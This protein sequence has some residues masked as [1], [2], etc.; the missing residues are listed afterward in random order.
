[1]KRMTRCSSRC[2]RG[3]TLLEALIAFVV[4]AGGLLAVFRFHSTTM[5]TTA[6]SKIRS[7]AVA[8]AEQKLEE[9]R[10]YFGVDDAG[11]NDFDTDMPSLSNTNF[12]AEVNTGE[13]LPAEFAADGYAAAFTRNWSVRGTNPRQVDVRVIWTDRVG[14]AQ[15]VQLSTLIW[16]T[17]PADSAAQFVGVLTEP[18]TTSVWSNGG[19]DPDVEVIPLDASG[20]PA[21]DED[22]NPVLDDNGDPVVIVF[23]D[24]RFSGS[25]ATIDATLDSVGLSRTSGSDT[26]RICTVDAGALTYNCYITHID[27]G[28]TWTGVIT[29]LVSAPGN[30]EGVC[31]LTGSSPVDTASLVFDQ[32]S[33]SLA[34][35]STPDISSIRV[36][37][38]ATGASNDC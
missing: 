17:I 1:M 37:K 28:D 20:D 18:D 26:S 22:G 6:E 21:L 33:T 5:E 34:T 9:L 11:G 14:A 8:L 13:N 25:Y 23:F 31:E 4:L 32:N 16:E 24:L 27:N 19:S 36:V 3:F 29:F 38:K 15:R 30:A 2:Q 12:I 10:S 35:A 7:E